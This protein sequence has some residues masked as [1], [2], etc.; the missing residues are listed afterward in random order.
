VGRCAYLKRQRE[1]WCG[2]WS[3]ADAMKTFF[4]KATAADLASGVGIFPLCLLSASLFSDHF[5]NAL[6]A[7]NRLMLSVAGVV[8]LFGALEDF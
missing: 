6:V 4:R 7:G 5:L 8:A 3:L 1:T 2:R